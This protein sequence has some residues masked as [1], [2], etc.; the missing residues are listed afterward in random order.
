MKIFVLTKLIIFVVPAV[1]GLI[2][3]AFDKESA[4]K[5][6]NLLLTALMV[7]EGYSVIGNA[8][9]IYTGEVLSEFD[10]ITFVFKKTAQKIKL[11]LEKLMK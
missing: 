2:W 7:A 10:A 3:G 6:V 11:L 1:A 9:T 5:I 8:Y 4:F